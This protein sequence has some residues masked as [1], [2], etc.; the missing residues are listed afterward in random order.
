MVDHQKRPHHRF[1]VGRR[2]RGYAGRSHGGRAMN[3]LTTP[4]PRLID[5]FAEL[6][7]FVQAF[8]RDAVEKQPSYESVRSEILRLLKQSEQSVEKGYATA[9]TYDQARYAV[10]AW[11][12]E[13]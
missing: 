3:S 8:R 7:G 12:D 1:C 6:M 9:E 11:I 4:Q 13:Q 10:C 2:A 5:G